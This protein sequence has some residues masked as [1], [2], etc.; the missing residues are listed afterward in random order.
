MS[1]RR[2]SPNIITLG[3]LATSLTTL[4]SALRSQY[5]TA[6]HAIHA[7][8]IVVTPPWDEPDVL[9]ENGVAGPASFDV[10]LDGFDPARKI[11]VIKVVREQLGVGLKEAVN[12]VEAAPGIVR[13]RL[14]K[15]DAQKLQAQLERAGGKVSLR[16]CL[17]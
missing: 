1:P 4:Q 8:S 6:T 12:L 7:A 10:V 16:P 17:A 15:D 13:A 3:D 9:V 5:L 2:Q 14:F 11:S